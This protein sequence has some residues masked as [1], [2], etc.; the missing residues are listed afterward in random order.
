VGLRGWNGTDSLLPFG[1]KL[2][3]PLGQVKAEVFDDVLENLGFFSKKLCILPPIKERER[4]ESR[5]NSPPS[6]SSQQVIYVLE[7][8]ATMLVDSESFEVR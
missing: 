8:C 2:V 6:W 5:P 7:E 1:A 3:L 4:G